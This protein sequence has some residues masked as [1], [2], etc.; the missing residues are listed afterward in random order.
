M[1]AQ[2]TPTIKTKYVVLLLATSILV[3]TIFSSVFTVYWI[4][5][6]NGYLW[7]AIAIG[8]PGVVV[9]ILVQKFMMKW[10]LKRAS[11]DPLNPNRTA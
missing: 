3:I 5:H 6:Q 2:L 7:G 11:E 1:K 10:V 4:D 9:L 8:L